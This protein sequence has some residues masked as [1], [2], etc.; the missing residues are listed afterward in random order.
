MQYK[1][2]GRTGVKVSAL[3]FGTMA[4]GADADDQTSASLFREALNAGINTFDCANIYGKGRAEL[5]LGRLIN[6]ARDE[7]V[8]T[9]KAYFPTG[10]GPNDWGLSRYHIV[11][12]VDASLRRLGTDRIDIF[13]LHRF[14][15]MTALEETLR[16]VDDLVRQ[17][18]I[19]YPAVSNFAAW[20]TQK[21]VDICEKYGWARPVCTQPMY[22]AVK[23]QAEVEIL[24]MA[25]SE[26]LG[27]L[28]YGPLAGGLLTGKYGKDRRPPAGRLLSNQMYKARYSDP[29]YYEAAEEFARIAQS[30]GVHPATLAV[31]WSRSHPAVTAPIIGARSIEQMR[32]LLE[33]ADYRVSDDL[34]REVADIWPSPP[35]ATDR[36]EE[37]MQ[38]ENDAG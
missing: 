9:T 13:F 8:L 14:D 32:P 31:A 3:V 6:H 26:G 23:R 34:Y 11:H 29:H 36:S 35:P 17:G 37:L 25:Q 28:P 12:S 30:A 15:N 10:K 20:Q 24:P 16:A 5:I 19:L 18:K 7:I 4:F 1:L 38:V 22:N 2:L 33:G 21:A 27:V